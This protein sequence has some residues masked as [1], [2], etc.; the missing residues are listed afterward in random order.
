MFFPHHLNADGTTNKWCDC[1]EEKTPAWDS[2]TGIGKK[3]REFAQYSLIPR[4]WKKTPYRNNGTGGL[5]AEAVRIQENTMI[6]DYWLLE[7]R[8]IR[9]PTL[10]LIRQQMTMTTF[11]NSL[12]N[13]M[14]Q[15][16]IARRVSVYKTSQA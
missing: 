14:K 11:V 10:S 16:S 13:S 1:Y 3:G 6:I 15:L 4:D 8:L 12:S 5:V 2:K 7:G 9:T